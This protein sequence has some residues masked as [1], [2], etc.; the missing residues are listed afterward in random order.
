MTHGVSLRMEGCYPSNYPS[1]LIQ[2]EETGPPGLSNQLKYNFRI[3]GF[4][5]SD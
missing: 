4:D 3:A 2:K 1:P 5:S